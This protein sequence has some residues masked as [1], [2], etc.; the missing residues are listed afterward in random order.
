MTL[1]HSASPTGNRKNDFMIISVGSRKGC[2]GKST[3]P[4][5]SIG[6]L[7]QSILAKAFRGEL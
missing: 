3:A 1:K 2:V 4:R 7:S 5:I 6:K